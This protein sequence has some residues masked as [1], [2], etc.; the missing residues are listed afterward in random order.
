MLPEDSIYCDL[1]WTTST[2]VNAMVLDRD[3][4]PINNSFEIFILG[5]IVEG[6]K[7]FT[8]VVDIL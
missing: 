3:D 7:F 1:W 6:S 5:L 8:C 4:T 2:G